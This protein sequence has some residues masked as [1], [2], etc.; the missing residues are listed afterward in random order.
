MDHAEL[1]CPFLIR[2]ALKLEIEKH[3]E[4]KKIGKHRGGASAKLPHHLCAR[5]E[6]NEATPVYLFNPSIYGEIPR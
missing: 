2:Q 1:F 4:G 6:Y 5:R 3:R